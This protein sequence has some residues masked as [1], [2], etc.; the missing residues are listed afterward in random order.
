MFTISTRT[1]LRN[2]DATPS[3][4]RYT[5]PPIIGDKVPHQRRAIAATLYGRNS[6][7]DYS[8]DYAKTPG[9]AGYSAGSLCRTGKCAPSYTLHDRTQMPR[10][11]DDFPGPGAYNAHDVRLQWKSSPRFAIG[12]RHS[13]FITPLVITDISD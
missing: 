8:Q 9:P 13:E 2:V 10:V 1:K 3:P 7:L 6:Y 12:V 11:K 4:N 5:L